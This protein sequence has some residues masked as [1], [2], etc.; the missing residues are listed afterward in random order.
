MSYS[1][2]TDLAIEVAET[3]TSNINNNI[4][5]VEIS[6]YNKE[7]NI[8]MTSIK[9]I[10]S[11]GERNMRRPIGNYV[12][13]ESPIIK[14]HNPEVHDNIIDILSREIIKL[15]DLNNLSNKNNLDVLLVGLGNQ[16]VTP[17]ALG[18]KVISKI[19]I[20]RHIKNN[21]NNNIFKN[22]SYVS[23]ISTGVMGTTGIETAEIVKGVVEK[24]K[25]NLV[26]AIDALATRKTS[27]INSTIQMTDTGIS[28]G[29]GMG[30]NRK[31]LNKETLGVPVIA[32]GVPT[33]VG[34][35]TLVND[36]LD[37]LIDNLISYIEVENEDR[38]EEN[39]GDDKIDSGEEFYKMLKSLDKEEKYNLIEEAL[40]NEDNSDIE[41]L[42]V[43]PKEVDE[44][45]NR[46]ARIISISINKALHKQDYKILSEY[47]N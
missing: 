22:I 43:T 47:I 13:L 18:P 7:N 45:V 17:D 1:I 42:F 21:K 27:R 23:A 39:I 10:N 2:K 9:I 28:P 44:V 5:G 4:E 26:I 24:T 35:A 12:T 20:T 38:E 11:I 19:L 8:D 25:P 30:N 46:L 3:L 36:T 31:Q 40:N 33:V 32:I 37:L 41:N 16:S 15:I 14:E 29:A 34:I 6:K